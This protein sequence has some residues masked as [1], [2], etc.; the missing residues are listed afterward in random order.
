M[1]A[2]A[3]SYQLSAIS[4]GAWLVVGCAHPAPTAN[5]PQPIVE[6]PRKP[7]VAAPP[8]G[9]VHAIVIR[10]GTIYDGSG[11]APFVGDVC[12]DDDTIAEVAPFCVGTRIVEARGLAVAP[13]FVNML[14]HALDSLVFDGRGASD[15]RQGVTLEV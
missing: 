6:A 2:R 8:T 15:L 5:A 7:A 10:G 1:T 12:I 13:G 9:P 14:S 3:V 11:A 4:F